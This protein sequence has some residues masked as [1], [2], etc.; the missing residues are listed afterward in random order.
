MI[1]G[2]K[3]KRCSFK[4]ND[5]IPSLRLTVRF[6]RGVHKVCMAGTLVAVTTCSTLHTPYPHTPPHTH[7][8]FP[9]AVALMSARKAIVVCRGSF[10]RPCRCGTAM[11]TAVNGSWVRVATRLLMISWSTLG[12]NFTCILS[13]FHLAGHA[14]RSDMPTCIVS[15]I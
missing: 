12:I 15:T 7:T 11:W 9:P 1:D 2:A 3:T 10:G 4:E 14:K 5:R 13:P 8:S 6:A